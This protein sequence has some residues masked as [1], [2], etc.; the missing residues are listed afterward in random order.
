MKFQVS[1]TATVS[2][3]HG[4]LPY[5]PVIY[6]PMAA[7]MHVSSISVGPDPVLYI[8]QIQPHTDLERLSNLSTSTSPVI[9][10]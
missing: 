8:H 2:V 4:D 7:A 3:A 10:G 6:R 1:D 9:L 5:R